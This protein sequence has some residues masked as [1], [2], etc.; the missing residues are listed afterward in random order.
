METRLSG[1]ESDHGWDDL[2]IAV[3]GGS[4]MVW[5]GWPVAVV[6]IQC[7]GFRSR[8][9]ARGRSIAERWSKGSRLVLALWEGNVT[10]RSRV[11]ASARGEAALGRGKGGDD[12]SWVDMNLTKPKK[13]IK[14]TFNSAGTNGWWR[15]KATMSWFF[16]KTYVSEI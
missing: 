10:W 2:F 14:L 15:F 12:V 13:W 7:F 11:A 4:Q 9:E 16:L 6:R 8:G 5:G 3:E 1:G